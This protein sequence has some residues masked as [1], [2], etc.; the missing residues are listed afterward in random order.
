MRTKLLAITAAFVTVAA[1]LAQYLPSP[2]DF[3]LA[4]A[5]V[6]IG[7]GLGIPSILFP[8]GV[9][10]APETLF[11]NILASIFLLVGV[12]ALL[13]AV[14]VGLNIAVITLVTLGLTYATFGCAMVR[15]R[16]RKKAPPEVVDAMRSVDYREWAAF[17]LGVLSAAAV[18]IGIIRLLS[19][20]GLA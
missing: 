10:S 2:F 15:E 16:S 6:L 5:V 14:N 7:P 8:R 19:I 17:G 1:F 13:N 3:W 11:L 12:L 18:T 9:L 4:L 20:L